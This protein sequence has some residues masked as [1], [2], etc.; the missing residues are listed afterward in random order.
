MFLVLMPIVLLAY[1]LH[2]NTHDPNLKIKG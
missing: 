2:L 1:N